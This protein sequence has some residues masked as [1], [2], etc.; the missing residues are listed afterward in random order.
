MNRTN[1]LLWVTTS[2]WGIITTTGGLPSSIS[3][4]YPYFYFLCSMQTTLHFFLV[5]NDILRGNKNIIKAMSLNKTRSLCC[6][7]WSSS[8]HLFI[9]KMKKVK[10][11]VKLE[12]ARFLF[13][14]SLYTSVSETKFSTD[15]HESYCFYTGWISSL[16]MK[17]FCKYIRLCNTLCMRVPWELSERRW[18][19][20][21]LRMGGSISGLLNLPLTISECSGLW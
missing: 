3:A 13:Q 8:D 5:E 4:G 16:G 11:N 18:A 19:V 1:E 21:E 14:K 15:I 10:I 7:G 2:H 12:H 20:S 6:T 9:N 17:K